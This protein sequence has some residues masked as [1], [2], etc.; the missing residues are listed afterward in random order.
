M[1]IIVATTKITKNEFNEKKISLK[2]KNEKKIIEQSN[3]KLIKFFKQIMRR[4]NAKKVCETKS[5]YID[6]NKNFLKQIKKLQIQNKY[7]QTIIFKF[8][9]IVTQTK[10]NKKKNATIAKI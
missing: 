3:I 5:I 7:Y 8:K 10:K 6:F 9:Y 2:N 1:T 4:T